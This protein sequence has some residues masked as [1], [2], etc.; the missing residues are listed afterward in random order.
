MHIFHFFCAMKSFEKWHFCINFHILPLQ[1]LFQ[2][3]A[4]KNCSTAQFW[5]T[6]ILVC[7]MLSFGVAFFR[8]FSTF[9]HFFPRCFS[10]FNLST[11]TG[12][13][14]E[15][16]KTLFCFAF[17]CSVTKV[18]I[19]TPNVHRVASQMM[20]QGEKIPRKLEDLSSLLQQKIVHCRDYQRNVRAI[21]FTFLRCIFWGALLFIPP[22]NLQQG[23]G[24]FP[25]DQ[26]PP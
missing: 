18:Q 3:I 25:F 13:F 19:I 9:W 24:M 6:F 12:I 4:Q 23:S 8:C 5:T 16:C 21:C 1:F 26:M 14:L 22:S 11:Q 17:M 15:K 10:N 7:T 20:L 2:A